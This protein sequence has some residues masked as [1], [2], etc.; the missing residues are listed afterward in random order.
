MILSEKER[1]LILVA[2]WF[3]ENEGLADDDLMKLIKRF[4]SEKTEPQLYK[5]DFGWRGSVSVVAT[6]SDEA[7]KLFIESGHPYI[8]ANFFDD[9]PS[10]LEGKEINVG[11]INVEYGD[12]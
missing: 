6:S 12:M 3:R 11:V 8:G 1:H 4:E 2:L 5:L 9:D 7:K 10:D